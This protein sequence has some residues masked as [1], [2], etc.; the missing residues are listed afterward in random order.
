MLCST[1]LVRSYA[2]CVAVV[3]L[4]IIEDRCGFFATWSSLRSCLNIVPPTTN[5]TL[6]CHVYD[7][8]AAAT[9][10]ERRRGLLR[11]R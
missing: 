7:I 9:A 2:R 5:N 6:T 4:S 1:R 11:G 8:C 10:E 3:A